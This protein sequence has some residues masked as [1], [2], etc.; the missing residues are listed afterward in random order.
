MK[1]LE[2]KA[3]FSID[4]VLFATDFSP[5]TGPALSYAVTIADR[6]RSEL[7]VAHVINLESFELLEAESAVVMIKQAHDEANR[8]IAQ[9]LDSLGLQRDRYQIVVAE[10]AISEVLLD[11][12]RRNHIDVAVLGTHG[13][14]AFKKLLMGS[15]AEE[16]FRMA[17]CPVL[18][19]G[20]KTRPATAER[21]L[22][23][24][25]YPVEFAPDSSKA[26]PYVVSLAERYDA[27]LTV[28]NVREDMPASASRTEEFTQPMERWIRD[29]VPEDSDLRKRIRFERGFGPV[30]D[31]IL[32]FAAKENVDMIVMSIRQLDPVMAAHLP[33]A[34]TAHELVSR[35]SCPVL[36]IRR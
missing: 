26:A 9:L 4:K 33:K 20:P 14:R 23:H 12:I 7:Y 13:R 17:P 25:L 34:G 11:I 35:A 29:H 19:V 24:I 10:G 6:Y 32:D 22:R 18:T 30:T 2:P 27:A 31:S 28:M 5:A 36:T 3:E 1:K 16:V 21:Q 15:I 8:K